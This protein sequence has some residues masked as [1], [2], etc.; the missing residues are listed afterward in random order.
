V[1]WLDLAAG[2]YARRHT[3]LDQTIGLV[4]GGERCLVIDTGT[5]ESHADFSA[6]LHWLLDGIVRS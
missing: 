3:E 2:V 6:A 5:D 4:V 1:T